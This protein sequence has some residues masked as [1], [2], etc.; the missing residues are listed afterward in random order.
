MKNDGII[1]GCEESK[2]LNII[3]GR[4]QFNFN[5]G[6]YSN[7]SDEILEKYIINTQGL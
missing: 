5:F 3:K 2:E 1:H 4:K 6:N 7:T